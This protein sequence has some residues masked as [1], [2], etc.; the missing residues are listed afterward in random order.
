MALG[1]PDRPE[2]P[3]RVDDAWVAAALRDMTAF[4]SLYAR[5]YLPI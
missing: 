2:E 5:Y 1:D 4:V 3:K